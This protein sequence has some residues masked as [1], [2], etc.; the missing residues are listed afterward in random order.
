VSLTNDAVSVLKNTFLAKR[1]KFEPQIQATLLVDEPR[2]PTA[3]TILEQSLLAV[4]RE[5]ADIRRNHDAI[6]TKTATLNTL[7]EDLLE[8]FDRAYQ[9][10]EQLAEARSQLAKAEAVAKFEHDAREVAAQRLSLMSA[11]FHQTTS[12][13]ERLR[14]EI[15][16]IEASLR[17]S[18]ETLAHSEAESAG[19]VEQFNAAKAEIERARSEEAMSRRELDATKIELASSNKFITQKVAEITLLLGRCEIAEQAARASAKS[20]EESRGESTS[21][22]VRLDEERVNLASA[23]SRIAAMKAQMNDLGEKFSFARSAWSQEAERFNETVSRLKDELGQACGRDEAHQRLLAVAQ[24]D[25]TTMRGRCGDLESQ[26]SECQHSLGELLTRAEV[27]EAG[28]D[29]LAKD[30]ATSK[31]LQ[32]S[33][34]RRVR[35]MIGAL[36]EKNAESE[37]K[38]TTLANFERRFLAYQTEAGGTIRTLQEKESQ[39][40]AELE[41]ERA[42]RVVSE[43][44]LAIDRSFR[45]IETHRKKNELEK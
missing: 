26:L 35:P 3:P 16:R 39:L 28:R 11:S 8:A 43:G 22:L 36:R 13:L 33:M 10:L 18:S 15:K 7:Q 45:P 42:R 37:D 41:T 14:P 25:L 1:Q 23:Q 38:A 17:Q 24:A 19:L 6:L 9:A 27:G 32:Q 21:A 44:A 2:P 5:S 40:V 12:E 4:A 20:L 30:L 29:Q 34:L 31:R